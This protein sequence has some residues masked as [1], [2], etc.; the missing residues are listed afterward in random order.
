VAKPAELI[1]SA[2][3][4]ELLPPMLAWLLPPPSALS[5]VRVYGFFGVCVRVRLCVCDTVLAMRAGDNA[6][7]PAPPPSPKPPPL[8]PLIWLGATTS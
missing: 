8:G 4:T 5:A 6:P 3:D 7:P 1:N 2:T